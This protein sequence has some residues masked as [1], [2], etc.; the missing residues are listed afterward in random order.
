M[1]NEA[2]LHNWF[3]GN[4]TVR[5]IAAIGFAFLMGSIP[6]G[7][8]F[9]WLFDGL[10]S[11]IARTASAL[12]PVFNTGKAIIPTAIA[13]HGGGAT[14][15]LAAAVALVAGHCYCPWRRF[16]GGSGIAV[17][18]GALAVL[19]WP[20]A[21]VYFALWMVGAVASNYATFG[22]VLAGGFSFVS[23]WFFLGAPGALAGF[24]MF[25]IV[26]SRHVGSFARIAEGRELPLRRPR[27][28]ASPLPVSAGER[29]SL[30]IMDGQAVQSF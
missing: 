1:V 17:M 13:F 29:T 19:S 4:I 28:A 25:L 11:R 7:P 27:Y 23:L 5:E 10:D 12:I 8:A 30:V 6:I 16:D 2:L 24:A 26:A 22:T 3:Y 18:F 14:V 9:H 21:T 15:G 20:S